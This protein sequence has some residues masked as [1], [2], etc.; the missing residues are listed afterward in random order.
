MTTQK[1][2]EFARL[3][4]KCL[5]ECNAVCGRDEALTMIR[6][7]EN[8]I[9]YAAAKKNGNVNEKQRTTAMKQFIAVNQHN[10]TFQ[11]GFPMTA[12]TLPG[13]M[14]DYIGKYGYIQGA[15][16]I[17]TDPVIGISEPD[18]NQPTPG[19]FKSA[20]DSFMKLNYTQVED[21]DPAS[22]DVH[23]A[24]VKARYKAE[25][26]RYT[27]T[28]SFDKAE[29]ALRFEL[30]NGGLYG[31]DAEILKQIITVLGGAGIKFYLPDRPIDGAK[32]ESQRGVAYLLP[33]RMTD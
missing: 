22:V 9:A 14:L 15:A 21:F 28:S 31:L 11:A 32:I 2:L 25:G 33:I 23:I 8:E 30:Q 1:F 16:L 27:K 3:M 7:L 29:R 5:V 24:S 19:V 6:E 13:A 20:L 18:K 10:D 26:R 12:D 4:L 17:I